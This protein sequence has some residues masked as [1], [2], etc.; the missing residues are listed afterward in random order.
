MTRRWI[1]IVVGVG[2]LAL[3][4]RNF[5]SAHESPAARDAAGRGV[6]LTTLRTS[7]V[8]L[9]RTVAAMR[10]A[11]QHDPANASAAVRLADAWLRLVRVTGNAGLAHAAEA[12]LK[13]ALESS[14]RAHAAQQ[15]LGAVYLSQ[16]RFSDAVALARAMIEAR[17]N[18]AWAYGVLGDGLLELGDR[19][20]AFDAFDRMLALRPDA[21][22]YG[23]A[24]YARELLGDLDGALRLMRMALDATSPH[25]P[26][27]VAWHHAQ[28]GELLLRR[29][30]LEGARRS[31]AH[32]E[33]TFTGHPL[34]IEGEA[35]VLATEGRA[36]EALT[37]L[38]S[39]LDS[40][41][42]ADRLGWA[43]DLLDT[44]GRSEEAAKYRHLAT[45]AR[46][47]EGTAK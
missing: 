27:S 23:R 20:A 26:E 22:A 2:A 6:T 40:S 16:H 44:N 18:D 11:L 45:A 19:D 35:R 36:A 3:V 7:R 28:I 10:A 43:A 34:A 13:R 47:S 21:A 25:D 32:A 5:S 38:R 33:F 29:H 30:D 42:T 12:A 15:M 14:P 31:F 46:L 1:A 17:P 9:D 8:E 24:A 37:L 39:L 4:G 41:P